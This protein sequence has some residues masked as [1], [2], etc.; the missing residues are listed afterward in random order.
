MDG[1][2]H[3]PRRWWRGAGVAIAVAAGAGTQ[4]PA[5]ACDVCAVYTATELRAGRPGFFLGAAE[6]FTH[7]AT[8]RLDGDEVPNPGERLDS[9]ITQILFGYNVTPAV[10]LQLG[11]PIVAKTF[12]RLEEGRLV[13]GAETGFGDLSL[14]AVLR[15]FSHV[16]ER[17]VLRVSLLGGLELP[18]GNP[19]A[20]AEER[21]EE[22]A[23]SEASGVHGHDLALGSGSV[24]GIL[25]GQLFWSWQRAFATLAG[26]YAIR[27]E[28]AFGYRYA[29]DLI[30][31]TGPGAFLLLAPDHTL[32]LQAVVAG[33]TKGQDTLDGEALDDTAITSVSLGPAFRFTW[34]TSLLAEVAA[35]LPLVQHNTSLQIVPDYRLRGAVT[36]HF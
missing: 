9:S 8:L 29:D 27:G 13:D 14:V 21:D 17:S 28:G 10:G 31:A 7:M 18:S 24:D 15:P 19:S 1:R 11:L 6:Q 35:E 36:W 2:Q 5:R 33:E 12:R 34:G 16:T 30:W 20:L 22:H 23:E 3:A 4:T 26:Q 32:S 25:G